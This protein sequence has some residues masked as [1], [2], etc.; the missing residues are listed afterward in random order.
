MTLAD[1][2]CLP[3]LDLG[4]DAGKNQHA[5]D[6]IAYK[7]ARIVRDARRFITGLNENISLAPGSK[8]TVEAL[9]GDDE[10]ELGALVTAILAVANTHKP[11]AAADVAYD[12]VWGR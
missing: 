9:L 7:A 11:T 8:A 5:A 12:G 3:E 1:T 4:T 6:I 2:D 10:G